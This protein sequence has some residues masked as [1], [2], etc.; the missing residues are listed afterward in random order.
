[1][2]NKNK[3]EAVANCVCCVKSRVDKATRRQRVVD[4]LV[5]KA[6]QAITSIHSVHHVHLPHP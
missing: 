5:L 4:H 2:S 1:M 6:M 3:V